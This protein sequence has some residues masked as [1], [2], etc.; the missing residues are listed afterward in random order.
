MQIPQALIHSLQPIEGFDRN[1]FLQA[2]EEKETLVSVRFNPAKYRTAIN[3][4]DSSGLPI[5][6]KIPWA[7][8][9]YYLTE[10]PSFTFDPLLHAGVYY[11]QEPSSMFLEEALRQTIDI[12]KPLRILDLCAAPGGKSTL[13]QSVISK[14]SLLVSNE[15]IRSRA[16]ILQENMIKWGANNVIVTSNDPADF[17][18]LKNYFDVIVVDAPCSGSGLFRKEPD[19]LDEWSPENVHHCS[20]RQQRI[21]A[22]AWPALKDEGVLVYATCSYSPE[23]DE[24]IADWFTD[25]FPSTGMRLHTEPGWGIAETHSPKNKIPGYRFFPG[26]VKGEGYFICC[27]QKKEGGGFTMPKT[28]K[29]PLT[30]T[31]NEMILLEPFLRLGSFSFIKHNDQVYSLMPEHMNDWEFLRV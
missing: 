21:L 1:S 23:E 7:S 15:V 30:L 2:H 3:T 29:N 27:I 4:R 9:G 6:S 10:R 16:S 25:Q 11:V 18:S 5:E 24:A 22:E 28:K 12:S 19:S 31:R 8:N 14:E 26:K 20:M 13:I 17:S